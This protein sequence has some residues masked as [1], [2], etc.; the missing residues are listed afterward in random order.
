[1]AVLSLALGI[2]ANTAIFGIINALMLRSLPVRDPQQLV[3]IGAADPEQPEHSE[4]ISLAMFYEIQQHASVFSNV[5]VWTGGGMSNIEAN[6]ATYA[7]TVDGASGDYFA[8]LGVRPVLGRL[9]TREDAPLDGRPSAQVAVLSYGCWRQR[10]GGDPHVLGRTIRV[11]AIPVTIVGV[12]P[13]DFTGLDIDIEPAA[14]VP[15]GFSH[16][17]L[18][19]ARTFGTAFS[20]A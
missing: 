20:V 18:K 3:S 7:G 19:Y 16:H 8:A 4:G 15:I 2:G 12:T 14:T 10:F 13:P 11:N 1:M 5:F 9:L 17:E 6:G